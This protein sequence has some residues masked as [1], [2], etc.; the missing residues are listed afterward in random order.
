M[1][2]LLRLFRRRHEVLDVDPVDNDPDDVPVVPEEDEL[3][4]QVPLGLVAEGVCVL[5]P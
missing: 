1:S 5:L 3:V 2:S 4:D